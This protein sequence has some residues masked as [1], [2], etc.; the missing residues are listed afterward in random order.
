MTKRITVLGCGR[1]GSLIAKRLAA[2]DFAVSVYDSSALS[3]ERLAGVELKLA[4]V[5]DLSDPARI[6][7]LA[8]ES[9]LVIGAL[10]G[11][12]GLMAMEAV[13]ETGKPLV[14]ISFLPEDP[15]GLDAQARKKGSVVVYDIGVAPGLSHLLVGHGAASLD[16]V[17]AA[18]I[19]VGGLPLAPQPPWYYS[20]PFSP[21]DVLE[22]YTRPTRYVSG[23]VEVECEALEGMELIELPGI[24]GVLEACFTDGLRSLNKN[25][26][27]R[28]MTEKTLR[29][30]GHINAIRVLRDGGF[31]S[32]EPMRIGGQEIIPIEFASAVLFPQWELKPGETEF[33]VMRVDVFGKKDGLSITRRWDVLDFTD[34][35]SDETSMA[36]TTGLP[37]VYAAQKVLEGLIDEPGIHAPET[38][39]QKERFVDGLLGYLTAEGVRIRETNP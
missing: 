36:R 6:A 29:W 30:P 10:P 24:E 26:K 33:T 38:L 31:F 4:Q 9:D 32:A 5:A 1:V 17:D 27:A 34:H 35:D 11:F 37:C 20:A 25:I 21:I 2:A 3:L 8:L 28:E 15:S 13:I 23:G 39:A 22:E 16:E 14:D 19:W 18:Y 12:M 7:K